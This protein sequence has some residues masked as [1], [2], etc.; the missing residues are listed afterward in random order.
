MAENGGDIFSRLG[1]DI[2]GFRQG[3]QE[4]MGITT[5]MA[6]RLAAA[7]NINTAGFQRNIRRASSYIRTA[8][9]RMGRSLEPV[10][11]WMRKITEDAE[12][13]GKEASRNFKN[14]ARVIQG[15]L[16]SQA[17]YTLLR[18]I[19]EVISS[20]AE[21]TQ[22][23]E[24]AQVSFTL[25]FKD[26]EKAERFLQTLRR[27]AAVT[28]FA[29]ESAR[30]AAQRLL[31]MG[32]EAENV[33]YV[34]QGVSD[35]TALAGAD[36]QTMERV[37]KALGQINTTGFVAKRQLLQLA[38]AGIP[39]FDILQEK[40]ELTGEELNN[41]G[42]LK[43]PADV[44]LQALLEGIQERYGGASK[45]IS[46]TM[47]GLLSTIKDN[48]LII[49]QEAFNDTFLRIKAIV[50][51]IAETMQTLT[52]AILSG[53]LG[54]AFE[55]LVPEEFQD[56]VRLLITNLRYLRDNV[57]RLAMAFAP[58][59]AAM[60]E[61][62]LNAA[63]FLLPILNTM[64]RIMSALISVVTENAFAMKLL[65]TAL[66]GLL[67]TTAITQAMT[68]FGAVL[69]SLLFVKT[70]ASGIVLL[71]RSLKLLGIA[72]AA[73]PVLLVG[74]VLA[75]GLLAIAF[76]SRKASK[77]TDKLAGSI[78]KLGGYDPDKVLQPVTKDNL[79]D[80]DEFNQKIVASEDSL[81]KMGDAGKKAGNKIKGAFQKFDEV[82]TIPEQLDSATK[83][84]EEL[85]QEWTLPEVDDLFEFPEVEVPEL[86]QSV[87]VDWWEDFK[88]G[89]Q[90]LFSKEFWADI[91]NGY[92]VAPFKAAIS[93]L[94][95]A[96]VR[97]K[98]WAST[99]LIEPFVQWGADVVF[100]F[101]KVLRSL[102][103][104]W[105]D[106]ATG[107]I[108]WFKQTGGGF[109][110]W[111]LE[112]GGGF[113]GWVAS[114]LKGL[115]GWLSDSATIFT[116][117]SGGALSKLQ[118]WWNMTSTGFVNWFSDTISGFA[119][120]AVKTGGSIG[121]WVSEAWDGLSGWLTDTWEGFAGWW[122]DTYEG[123]KKWVDDILGLFGRLA[124]TAGSLWDDIFGDEKGTKTISIA[125]GLTRPS[126]LGGH[127]EGGIFNKEHI[128]RFAEGNKAEAII[129]L[130]NPSAMQPFVDAVVAGIARGLSASPLNNNGTQQEQAP[131]VYQ[132]GTLIADDR[133]LRQLAR[134]VNTI[135][136]QEGGRI[137]QIN[138]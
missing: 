70:L 69:R 23:F 104:W 2:S 89:W 134:K 107:F 112:T 24:V 85:G 126:S 124:E 17:F 54:K 74:A 33:L 120:W 76:N 71:T 12:T 118:S 115:G 8:G 127:A 66:T 11:G 47:S 131:V 73:N 100:E 78:N 105:D 5:A 135:N 119:D 65:V 114:S 95:L 116:Q 106:T 96:W 137:G 36:T 68:I 60:S 58:L 32:I 25:L 88:E 48:F 72:M 3:M 30:R 56:K 19:R 80:A 94:Q 75:G 16:I 41:I 40:L 29:E 129:P 34:L 51:K 133:S 14:V 117:W 86:P 53:G 121:D 79:A 97:F 101:A 43:I 113:V 122:S 130:Q 64:H 50:E 111:F 108:K 61:A 9:Q 31:A 67:I 13:F 136:L 15:I 6:S 26:Q 125:E 7:F 49:M 18:T 90:L 98:I 45:L 44:G 52:D 39:A 20:I 42:R 92:V 59:A 128:A 110:D 57:V 10:R 138:T 21:M 38:Q 63:N 109:A 81:K 77:E 22:A 102:T 91:W 123:F 46:K 28:P 35:A 84:F 55:T 62:F 132:V 103:T 27:F 4:A 37:S 93:D 99:N 1:V 82:F 83:S 87:I